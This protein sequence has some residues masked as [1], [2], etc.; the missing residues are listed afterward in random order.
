MNTNSHTKLSLGGLLVT[1][2]IIYGD[3]GTSPLYVMKA[4]VGNEKITEELAYGGFSCVFWTLAIITTF[5]YVYLALSVDNR[6]EGGIFALYA[7]VR[8]Y[9]THW[10][11][12]PAIIGCGALIADGFI[13]P[14][15]SV[16]SAVEGLT[17]LKT[18]AGINTVPIVLVILVILF[19]FQQFGT[20]VVGKTFGPIM[21]IWFG[22]IAYLGLNQIIKYPAVLK[23]FNPYY[24]IN[25]VTNYRGELTHLHG[26]WL[27]GAVFLCTT[28]GEALYSDL[29]HCGRDNI[30]VSWVGVFIG[31]LMCYLGQAALLMNHYNG[32]VFEGDSVFYALMSP[33]FL[34][35]GI[36]ISTM[37]AIIASQALITGCFTLVNEAM[38]LKLWPNMKVGY[39][40]QMQGQIYIPSINWFLMAGCIGIVLHFEKSSNMDAAY[41]L[42]IILNMLMTSLLMMHYFN[43]RRRSKP[44]LIFVGVLLVVVEMAYMVSNLRKFPHGGWVSILIAGILIFCIYMWYQAKELRKLHSSFVDIKPYIPMLEAMIDDN[45]IPKEA[46][47]LVYMSMSSNDQMIDSNIVYSIFKKRP[48]RA[49]IYW[50]VHVDI[51]DD[52]FL[53]SYKVSTL[54]PGKV[55]FVKLKFGFKVEHKV[56]LMFSKIVEDMQNNNEVDELSHY[57]SLREYNLPAD[58]KFILINSRVS[59]DDLLSPL[60]QFIV[61]FYRLLKKISLPTTEDF[62]LELSNTELDTIPIKV[63]TKVNIDLKREY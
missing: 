41:G 24:A 27:L 28:G 39:P 30:R 21:L 36:A 4:I 10:V 37:A 11:I 3:I 1:L 31:L 19:V 57:N 59:V 51:V 35:F 18:F 44:F 2:G 42:A 45:S 20:N 22:M 58:F 25:L 53:K 32:K 52:P 43:M 55:F 29:G 61:R 33:E 56:N 14:P 7:L 63:G 8:R 17:G 40:T 16:A 13:T 5:K 38:K 12:Y 46:T 50:F 60:N 15:I 34:P 23:A 48:R 62:G 9:K 54:V 6:G 49:D 26:F 47:N